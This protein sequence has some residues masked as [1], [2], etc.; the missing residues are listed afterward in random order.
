VQF[1]EREIRVA[2]AEDLAL[3]LLVGEDDVSV[4][5]LAALP[6]FDRG[7]FNDRLVSIGLAEQVIG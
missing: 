5:K 3:L 4:R 6:D 7:A 2:A 1:E